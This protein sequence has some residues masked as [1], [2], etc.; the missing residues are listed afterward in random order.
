MSISSHKYYIT[1]NHT[2]LWLQMLAYGYIDFISHVN[3][4]IFIYI[5][6]CY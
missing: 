3:N 6:N 5:I 1:H 4:Q 2:P